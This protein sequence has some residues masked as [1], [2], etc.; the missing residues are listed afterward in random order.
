MP[1]KTL[2]II[3]VPDPGILM[4]PDKIAP[5]FASTTWTSS[6]RI[7]SARDKYSS[8]TAAEL[9]AEDIAH[10]DITFSALAKIDFLSL[11]PDL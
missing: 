11:T 4:A 1:S 10:S 9:V 5:N 8:F 2:S 6:R 3:L 7:G